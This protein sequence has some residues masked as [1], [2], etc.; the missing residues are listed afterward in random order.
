MRGKAW[1]QLGSVMFAATLWALGPAD[2]QEVDAA[3]VPQQIDLYDVT[4]KYPQPAWI[5]GRMNRTEILELSDFFNEQDGLQFVLEQI[6]A[7]QKFN[8]WESYYGLFAE[9]LTAVQPVPMG[10]F[11]ELSLD[12]EQ[13]ACA[14]GGFGS[15]TV[16]LSD[17]NAVLVTVCGSTANGS[18]DVGYGPEVGEVSVWRFIVSENTYIKLYHRWRGP[19]FALDMPANWPVAA[20]ALREIVRRMTDEVDVMPGL[21]HR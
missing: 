8:D 2:A 4:L 20:G 10:T 13:H 12:P 19:A 17:D 18:R 5:S 11:V 7:N 6:P 16:N 15:Q 21:A 3:S 14:A 1:S 9:T